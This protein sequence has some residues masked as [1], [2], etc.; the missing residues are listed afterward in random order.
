MPPPDEYSFIRYLSA[1]KTVDDRSLNRRV[2]ETLIREVSAIPHDGPLQILEIGAGIGTMVERALDWDLV[3]Q[4]VYTALD[5]ESENTA[6]AAVRLPSWARSRGYSVAG[7]TAGQI[8]IEGQGKDLVV[9]LEAQDIFG[10]MEDPSQKGQWDLL[11]A[12]AFLDLIDVRLAL[13]EI[14]SFL[15]PGGRF[16]FTV[17]FDG[18]TIF[19]PEIDKELD[20][21]IEGL[22]HETMDR[23]IIRGRP[24]GDSRTGRHFFAEAR[25]AGAE[26][27][28]SGSSDWVVFAGP[29]GYPADEAYFLHFIIH[30]VGSA[31]AGR[32]ELD[33]DRFTAWIQ[34]R[35][36]QVEQGR[37]VYI[38]HQLDFLG[39]VCVQKH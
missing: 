2:W 11:I 5:S 19:Q 33:P 29:R 10:F 16:Y 20:T 8:H 15:K 9:N 21:T 3:N 34:E 36:A 17:T 1:K 14:L 4:A 13:P 26:I 28:D 30:T 6:E 25:N 7:E 18:S 38:A 39:R 35:H 32:P 37:L 27:L 23:R 24:S 31:L 12:N 22:Y